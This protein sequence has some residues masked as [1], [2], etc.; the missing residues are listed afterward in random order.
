MRV[1]PRPFVVAPTPRRAEV[2]N[3]RGC[4][5][6]FYI[7]DDISDRL[8]TYWSRGAQDLAFTSG[9]VGQRTLSVRFTR[10]EGGA[11]QHFAARC[12]ACTYASVPMRCGR[13][14]GEARLR[15]L[16]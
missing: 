15:N 16:R 8:F 13:E 2:I 12:F 4:P 11:S 7:E 9:R 3:T 10:A 14:G 5:V 1:R 6:T